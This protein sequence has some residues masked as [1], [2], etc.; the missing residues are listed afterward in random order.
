MLQCLQQS[1]P[2]TKSLAE[3]YEAKLQV[4]SILQSPDAA[5]YQQFGMLGTENWS[6]VYAEDFTNTDTYLQYQENATPTFLLFDKTG[7]LIDRWTGTT[8][9]L[10]KTEQYLNN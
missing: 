8:Q 4:V 2:I 3:K 6:L 10:E 9:H 5:T 1:F 7:K